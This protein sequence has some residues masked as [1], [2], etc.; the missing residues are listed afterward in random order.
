[1]ADLKDWLTDREPGATK[2]LAG[3]CLAACRKALIEGDDAYARRG[4][5]MVDELAE[6]QRR[7]PWQDVAPH[8]TDPNRHYELVLESLEGLLVDKI[9]GRER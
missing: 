1:M 6:K 9:R 7:Q 3:E 4:L 2:P 5:A 8:Y